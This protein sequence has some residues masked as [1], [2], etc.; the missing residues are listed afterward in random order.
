MVR[1]FAIVGL[2]LL[3]LLGAC[4]E[5]DILAHAEDASAGN[6]PNIAGE[7]VLNGID[8]KGN[9]YTGHLTVL[10]GDALNSYELRWI[11]TEAFQEGVGRLRGNTLEVEWRTADAAAVQTGGTATLT[12]TVDGELYGSKRISG[13][14]AEWRE[15]AYPIPEE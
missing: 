7:Y 11:V 4:S 12:V 2:V 10:E 14:E 13:E 9:E 1:R 6:V 15:T 3:L 5:E 8:P